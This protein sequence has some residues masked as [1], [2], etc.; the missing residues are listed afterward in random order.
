M[1]ADRFGVLLASHPTERPPHDVPLIASPD[2]VLAPT[3]GAIVP[4]WVIVVPRKPALNFRSWFKDTGRNP[5]EIIDDVS[6]RL[7]VSSDRLLWFEHGPKQIG[8]S[9]GCGV[10]YAHLHLILDA[11]FSLDSLIEQV[12]DSSD[13]KWE[14]IMSRDAFAQLITDD[15][16]LVIGQGHRAFFATNVDHTGSQFLRRVIARTV[17]QP[18]IWNYRHNPQFQNI[19]QTIETFLRLKKG[20]SDSD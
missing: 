14:S 15:S 6:A 5:H 10:D 9:V 4:N 7:G 20:T 11:P 3:L 8:T 17:G 16:Y 2:W 12:R 19:A 1:A 18:D 13:L